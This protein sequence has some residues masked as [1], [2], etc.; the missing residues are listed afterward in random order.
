MRKVQ[1]F[2]YVKKWIRMEKAMLF[3][4]SNK[5]I[6]IMFADGSEILLTSKARNIVYVNTRKER[7]G[8]TL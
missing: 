8:M 3:R 6:Q 1:S 7:I 4:L 5:I 2:I